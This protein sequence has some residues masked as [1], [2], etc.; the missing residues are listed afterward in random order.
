M[1]NNLL[2]S[3]IILQS[4]LSSAQ[5]FEWV[6]H[7]TQSIPNTWSPNAVDPAGNIYALIGT[8][9]S[10]AIIQGDTIPGVAPGNGEII[11]KFNPTG[12]LLWSKMV[13]CDGG[14]LGLSGIAVDNSGGV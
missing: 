9:G 2:L 14:V 6:S 5:R 7:S 10:G 1:K 11:A 3:A 13:S 12:N 8:T 4:L